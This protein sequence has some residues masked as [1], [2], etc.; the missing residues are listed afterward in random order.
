MKCAKFWL[1]SFFSGLA[2]VSFALSIL[3]NSL[4]NVNLNLQG[5]LLVNIQQ[6]GSTCTKA[7]N[8]TRTVPTPLTSITTLNIFAAQLTGQCVYSIS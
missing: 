6:G 7:N 3:N 5:N 1:V 8:S 4:Y 2:K